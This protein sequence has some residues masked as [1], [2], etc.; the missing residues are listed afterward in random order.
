MMQD[1]PS[2]IIR[3]DGNGMNRKPGDVLRGEYV[4]EDLSAEQIKALE[5][6]VLWYTEGKGDVDMAV[7][8]FWRMDVENGDIIDPR[9]PSRFETVL[10]NSPLSYTGQIVKV[11]WCVRVRAFVHRG[12]EIVGQKE[13]RLGNVLPVKLEL[14]D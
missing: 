2:V 7:H 1:E 4:F 12:K 9:R 10:P 13:F 3:L 11:R 14:P 5:C 6:S 8:E